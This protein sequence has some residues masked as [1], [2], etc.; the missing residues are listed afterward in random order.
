MVYVVSI[1]TA[2]FVAGFE[3]IDSLRRTLKSLIPA[4]LLSNKVIYCPRIGDGW[5][6]S[7]TLSEKYS[8]K[9][10]ALR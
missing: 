8:I 2:Y 10:E 6:Q 4:K 1:N 3:S 5:G 7:S 9:G